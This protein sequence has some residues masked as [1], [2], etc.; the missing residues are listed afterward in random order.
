M[1]TLIKC[2]AAVAAR[3]LLL[4]AAGRILR[5]DF[6]SPTLPTHEWP[7]TCERAP[8]SASQAFASWADS[9]APPVRI[10]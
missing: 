3:I 1:R 9:R 2:R 7:T 8:V 5:G 4:A 6:V 10:L